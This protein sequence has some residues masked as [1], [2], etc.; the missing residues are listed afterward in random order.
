MHANVWIKWIGR[1]SLLKEEKSNLYV[2]EN[3]ENCGKLLRSGN[4]SD[5]KTQSTDAFINND[6]NK[7]PLMLRRRSKSN[8][9]ELIMMLD[10]KS[11]RNNDSDLSSKNEDKG[12]VNC[13][14][15]MMYLRGN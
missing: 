1:Y 2:S 4:I 14:T 3:E 10:D 12:I 9:N 13:N 6:S 11:S 7:K 8:M 5:E 15:K